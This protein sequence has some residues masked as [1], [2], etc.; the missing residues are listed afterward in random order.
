M[1]ASTAPLFDA[2]RVYREAHARY[3]TAFAKGDVSAIE[4]AFSRM[5][6]IIRAFRDGARWAENR[7]ADGVRGDR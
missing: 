3:A 2:C 4:E 6:E 7:K 5:Q 1:S